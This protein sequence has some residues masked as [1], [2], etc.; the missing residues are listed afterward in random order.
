MWIFFPYKHAINLITIYLFQVHR[1]ISKTLEYYSEN[2]RI[3][4]THTSL[5]GKYPNLPGLQ[6]HFLTTN[7]REKR[8]TELI[9]YNDCLY[10]NMYKYEYLAV[11]DIDEVIV[12]LSSNSWIQ[13]ID[14]LEIKTANSKNIPKG[15]F[16]FRNIYFFDEPDHNHKWHTDVPM[17]M[18]MLQHDVRS[19]K[20]SKPFNYVK[21]FM[22]TS[23]V[24]TIHNHLPRECL[25][26]CENYPVDVTDGQLQHYRDDCVKGIDCKEYKKSNVVDSNLFRYRDILVENVNKALYDIGLL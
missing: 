24:L 1:N 11:L 2:D 20:H 9:P 21:S 25:G 17:Y 8:L 3:L 14:K 19:K 13:L 7:V 10:K 4:V 18:H 22:N 12:P 26:K 5:P 6:H 23:T 15:S 16:V